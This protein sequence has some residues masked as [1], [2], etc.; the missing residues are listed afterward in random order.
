[1]VEHGGY[2]CSNYAWNWKMGFCR[3]HLLSPADQSNWREAERAYI[4]AHPPVVDR[5][6]RVS[7]SRVVAD[8]S[9][10]FLKEMYNG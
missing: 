3:R 2:M 10:W 1:M 8:S 7:D 4:R 6:P 5:L 9:Q